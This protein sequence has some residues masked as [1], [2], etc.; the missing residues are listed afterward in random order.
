M[1][2]KLK[3]ELSEAE[4]TNKNLKAKVSQ[5]ENLKEQGLTE[6][7]KATRKINRDLRD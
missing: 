3:S 7:S 5:E 4:L 6:G 2:R 1:L